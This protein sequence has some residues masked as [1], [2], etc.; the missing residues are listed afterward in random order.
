MKNC[1]FLGSFAGQIEYDNFLQRLC[2]CLEL[3][4]VLTGCHCHIVSTFLFLMLS[5]KGLVAQPSEHVSFPDSDWQAAARQ[6]LPRLP[7]GSI[8]VCEVALDLVM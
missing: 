8:V 6:A 7:Q 3:P 1:V 2:F 4:H 5:D